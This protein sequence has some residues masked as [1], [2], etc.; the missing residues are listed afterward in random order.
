MAESES[1]MGVIAAL[2]NPENKRLSSLLQA[3]PFYS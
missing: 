2:L 3:S 1:N